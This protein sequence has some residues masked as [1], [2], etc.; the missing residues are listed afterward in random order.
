LDVRLLQH[1]FLGAAGIVFIV[2]APQGV[3][4]L[5]RDPAPAHYAVLGLRVI[6]CGFLFYGYGMVLTQSFNGA[7]DTWMPTVIN[8]FCCWIL[9]LPVAYLLAYPLGRGPL[10]VFIAR[11]LAFST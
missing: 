5:T 4:A 10:G 11:T 3:H 8:F 1:L 6:S 2:L 7:G 9:E